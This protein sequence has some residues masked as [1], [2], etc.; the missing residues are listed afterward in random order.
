[1]GGEGLHFLYEASSSNFGSGIYRPFAL[2]FSS[3]SNTRLCYSVRV[4]NETQLDCSRLFSSII[5]CINA[6]KTRVT[7]RQN[8]YDAY[9]IKEFY[10]FVGKKNK[11]IIILYKKNKQNHNVDNFSLFENRDGRNYC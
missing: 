11:I 2:F 9:E 5:V 10:C 3:Y 4:P 7:I 1:M 6:L 8:D